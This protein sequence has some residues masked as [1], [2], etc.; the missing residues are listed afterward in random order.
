MASEEVRSRLLK[1]REPHETSESL[2]CRSWLKLKKQVCNVNYKYKI[3]AV[4]GR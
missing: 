1:Q 3:T 4:E 2:I